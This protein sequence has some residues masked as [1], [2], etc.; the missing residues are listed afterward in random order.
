MENKPKKLYRSR[1][2]RMAAG[3]CGGLGDYFNADANL[4]RILTA[5][6]CIVT[7]L[8]PVLCV[9]AFCALVLPLSN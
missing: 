2:N 9:Y 1:S 6:L 7:G 3:V 8:A 5:I 4:I